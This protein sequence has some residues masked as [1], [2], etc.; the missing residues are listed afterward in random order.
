MIDRPGEK[1]ATGPIRNSFWV[2]KIAPGEI[3]LKRSHRRIPEPT[4]SP[5]SPAR[6]ARPEARTG[7]YLDVLEAGVSQSVES[8]RP[9]GQGVRSLG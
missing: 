1:N 8:Q 4:L 9:V 5:S 3:S 7:R 2:S 6:L